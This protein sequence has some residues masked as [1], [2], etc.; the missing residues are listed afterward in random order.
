VPVGPYQHETA[1]IERFGRLV[2]DIAH[3]K[4]YAARGGGRD[5]RARVGAI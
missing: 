3:A 1:L 4:R 5:K 2:N